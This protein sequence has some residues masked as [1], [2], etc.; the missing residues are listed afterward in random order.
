MTTEKVRQQ[1]AD[2]MARPESEIELDRA[3]LLIAAEEYPNLKV[4]TYLA[5]LDEFAAELRGQQPPLADPLLRL[6]TIN[7]YLFTQSGFQGNAENYYDA[8]NSFLNDVMDRRTGLP[9]TLSVIYIELA[10]RLELKVQGV[11]LPGHF[12]VKYEDGERQII[13]DPFHAGRVISVDRCRE[14]FDQMSGGRIPFQMSF[15]TAVTKRQILTRMLHNLKGVYARA[16][17]HHK[18][19][20]VIERALLL[21]PGEAGEIRDR[22]LVYLGMG[23]Y[24][25]ALTDLNSYLKQRPHAEDAGEIRG[26]ITEL[27][28][29]QARLN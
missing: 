22:G 18:M 20:S 19:L 9:I 14:M 23:K 10:R 25:Q 27:H 8:R 13:I 3:A 7:D 12:L 2:T 29:R 26:K 11:G 16:A 4:E 21:N 6:L 1:F 5:R 28:Q 17:D 24:A 15:L